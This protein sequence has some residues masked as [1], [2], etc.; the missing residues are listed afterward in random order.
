M[1]GLLVPSAPGNDPEKSFCEERQPEGTHSTD[2]SSALPP[3]Q[4]TQGGCP[5]GLPEQVPL[6]WMG[7]FPHIQ[8]KPPLV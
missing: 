7:I 2:H 4:G 5:V 1:P 3:E 6:P 8:P